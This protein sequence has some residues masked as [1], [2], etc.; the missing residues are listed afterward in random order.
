[1]SLSPRFFFLIRRTFPL[2]CVCSEPP[3]VAYLCGHMGP[4]QCHQHMYSP[5][6]C[7]GHREGPSGHAGP[8]HTVDTD[9]AA[10]LLLSV[11]EAY[12]HP[13]GMCWS[14]SE[15]QNPG[16]NAV[17][18][19]LWAPTLGVGIVRIFAI[20][21]MRGW[22]PSLGPGSWVFLPISSLGL[23]DHWG[24]LLM[25]TVFG[26]SV[27]LGTSDLVHRYCW[28]H[29]WVIGVRW[30][31]VW[32]WGHTPVSHFVSNTQELKTGAMHIYILVSPAEDWGCQISRYGHSEYWVN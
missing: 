15:T 26:I 3:H 5:L 4:S 7:Q 29:W 25:M 28:F 31:K 18:P 1:M 2:V 20:L 24:H 21:C 14:S 10:L 32:H 9:H 30:S 23:C 13:C 27:D 8:A 12:P 17:G 11:R 19:G 22:E 6:L 16:A